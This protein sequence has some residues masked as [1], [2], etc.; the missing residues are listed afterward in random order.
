MDN[1][2]V[3]AEKLGFFRVRPDRALW[4]RSARASNL[5]VSQRR[6]EEN[7]LTIRRKKEA[8]LAHRL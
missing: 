8:N 7:R 6:D 1:T 3:E 2:K 5:W 4:L